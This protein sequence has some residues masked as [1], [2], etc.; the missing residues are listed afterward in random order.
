M[1]ISR[2]GLF[3]GGVSLD[4]MCCLFMAFGGL[5][6][7]MTIDLLLWGLGGYFLDQLGVSAGS[8][9]SL[10]R[11]VDTKFNAEWSSVESSDCPWPFDNVTDSSD[12]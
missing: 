1:R 9:A 10:A 6:T 7:G 8:E 3:N 4:I 5:L 11:A 2:G 12:L